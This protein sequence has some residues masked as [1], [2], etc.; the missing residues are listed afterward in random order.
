MKEPLRLLADPDVDPELTRALRD[1]AAREVAFDVEAGLERLSAALD[2]AAPAPSID[3]GA[4]TG[5]KL[6]LLLG[7]GA[8]GIVAAAIAWNATG[9]RSAPPPPAPAVISPAPPQAESIV[10]P[11]PPPAPQPEAEPAPAAAAPRKPRAAASTP[12][13]Q[14]RLAE[15]VRHLAEVRRLAQG[16]PAAAARA[17]DEG[18]ARFKGG[19]L[20]Q[21]REAVAIGALARS[22]RGSEARSRGEQF[23]SRFPKSPFADQVRSATGIA[24]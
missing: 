16:N 2:A 4:S 15:E 5:L 8:A 1:E 13:R 22:G 23:L 24:Q 7:A 17:A 21:E 6:K 14:E 11:S 12:S 3:A 9:P 10:V 19:M 20:Y 18:H